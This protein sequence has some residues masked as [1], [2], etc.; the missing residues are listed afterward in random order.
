MRDFHITI[1]STPQGNVDV[2]ASLRHDLRLLKAAL[3]YADRIRLCSFTS[4]AFH[5]LDNLPSV[6]I[7]ERV[8]IVLPF[9]KAA[10]M[11]PEHVEVMQKIPEIM[12]IPRRRLRQM[13][14]KLQDELKQIRTALA[15]M[16]PE[17]RSKLEV[18]AEE[19]QLQE[20]ETAVESGMVELYQFKH[21]GVDDALVLEYFETVA[22]AVSSGE[23]YPLF[24]DTTGGLIGSAIREQK[25]QTTEGAMN[26]ARHL[27]LAGDLL[28]RLPVFDLASVGEVIDIRRALD[29]P[30]VRFRGAIIKFA[31]SIE[32]APW[33]ADFAHDAENVFRSEI[34]PAILDIEESIRS[35]T[36]LRELTHKLA[37]KTIVVGSESAFGLL[38][39]SFSDLPKMVAA[40]LGIAVGIATIAWDTARERSNRLKE[41]ERNQLYFYYRS[42]QV[43]SQ[44][45]NGKS[46][47]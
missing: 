3:L 43:L 21:F 36:Y 47:R 46:N 27:A 16:W 35:N 10:G 14:K 15:K 30:L 18:L 25:L 5:S 41:I 19:G 12:A 24:D 1:G 33:D 7:E 9:V 8:R 31:L 42:G 26:R 29:I 39:S 37:T 38:L 32:N 20:L 45:R 6:S 11:S 40:S 34:E 44:T 4:A 22:D 17:I 13:P 28:Q 23:T 2:G